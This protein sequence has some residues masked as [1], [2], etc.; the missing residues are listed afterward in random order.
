MEQGKYLYWYEILEVNF[1]LGIIPFSL[2][3]FA[4]FVILKKTKYSSKNIVL[5]LGVHLLLSY[6]ISLI[7]LINP[8]CFEF[9]FGFLEDHIVYTFLPSTIG[10]CMSLIITLFFLHTKRKLR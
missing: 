3:I 6:C 10:E 8:S 5:F 2:G 9:A 7:L 4:L 1:L